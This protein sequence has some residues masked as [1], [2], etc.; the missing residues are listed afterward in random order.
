MSRSPVEII[1]GPV[2]TEK[3]YSLYQEGRYTFK[4][5]KRA[6]KPEIAKALEDHYQDQGIQV[7]RVHTITMHGKKR[8]TGRRGV[9]GHTP[10]WKKAI[11]TLAPGQKLEGLFGSL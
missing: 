7:A 1:Y 5:D 4:V 2:I 9:N 11:V 8:R 10:S 3:A 6:T